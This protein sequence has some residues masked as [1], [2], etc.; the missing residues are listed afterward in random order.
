MLETKLTVLI[1]KDLRQ[2]AKAAAAIRGETLSNVVRSAL[3]EYV[4]ETTRLEQDAKQALKNDPLLSLRFSGGP[5]DV[6]ERV[7]EI[8]KEASDPNTGLR[9]GNDRTR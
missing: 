2:Q 6:A 3:V 4:E 5:G 8:L 1:T 9:V 7:E